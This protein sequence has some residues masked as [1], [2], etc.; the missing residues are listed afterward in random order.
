MP[1]LMNVTPKNEKAKAIKLLWL[2][3]FFLSFLAYADNILQESH[4]F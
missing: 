4:S 3:K 1:F 2:F